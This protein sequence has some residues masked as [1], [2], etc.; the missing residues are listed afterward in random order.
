MLHT[1]YVSDIQ[2]YMF[3]SRE[4]FWP[5]LPHWASNSCH[6]KKELLHEPSYYRSLNTLMIGWA[7]ILSNFRPRDFKSSDDISH[8]WNWYTNTWSNFFHD[9]CYIN[10][11]FWYK[12]TV[13]TYFLVL[14]YPTHFVS[15]LKSIDH[16]SLT[17]KNRNLNWR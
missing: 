12:Y 13:L 16:N 2:M 15:V 11:W 4:Y 8:V 17:G 7:W 9:I 5:C 3:L 14:I 6:G 1:I 10:I